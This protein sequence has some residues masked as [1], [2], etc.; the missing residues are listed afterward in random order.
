MQ[1]LKQYG[2]DIKQT[3]Q[4]LEYNRELENCFLIPNRFAKDAQ[5]RMENILNT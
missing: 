4:I 1:L 3:H 2:T 5:W